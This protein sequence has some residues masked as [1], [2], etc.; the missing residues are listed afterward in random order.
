M[1]VRFCRRS[2]VRPVV[3]IRRF[4]LLD[5]FDRFAPV[6]LFRLRLPSDPGGNR[7][8][9]F[10]DFLFEIDEE[11]SLGRRGVKVFQPGENAQQENGGMN[12]QG[13]TDSDHP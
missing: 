12:R 6:D 10:L 9:L 13:E 4:R 11:G 7:D 5:Q 8:F 1:G 2:P 3:D